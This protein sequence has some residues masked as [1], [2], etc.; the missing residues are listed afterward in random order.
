M[1]LTQIQGD[2]VTVNPI[3]SNHAYLQR[4]QDKVGEVT[5]I[6]T[7]NIKA[8]SDSGEKPKD[9]IMN[10]FMNSINFSFGFCL[11]RL[12]DWQSKNS[13]NSK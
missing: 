6:N 4:K 13:I 11:F 1:C 2:A 12:V 9:T 5:T 10:C 7:C 8:A 3:I